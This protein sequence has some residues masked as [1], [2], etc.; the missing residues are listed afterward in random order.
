MSI[1]VLGAMGYAR[2]VM[3]LSVEEAVTVSFCTLALAQLWHV[4]NMRDRRASILHNEVTRNRW[5]WA[6]LGLCLAGVLG[7]VY[8]GPVSKVL[9]LHT[10][11]MGAWLLILAA[12]TLPLLLGPLVFRWTGEMVGGVEP[13]APESG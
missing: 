4:F 6:A 7:A 13:R 8:L 3:S 5:V 10:P 9:E 11:S 2:T 1:A 12:S